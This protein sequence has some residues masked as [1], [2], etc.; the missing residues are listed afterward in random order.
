MSRNLR[1]TWWGRAR[2][3]D[4]RGPQLEMLED[5][6]MPSLVD[7]TILVANAGISP[8]SNNDPYGI[9]A[10]DPSLVAR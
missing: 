6:V 3:G 4:R 1:R 9:L 5:R 10:V 7:G 2:P 8:W